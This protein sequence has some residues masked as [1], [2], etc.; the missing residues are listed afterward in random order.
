MLTGVDISAWQSDKNTP[1]KV[2]FVKMA[3]AGAKFAF[4]RAQFGLMKDVNFDEYVTNSKGLLKRGA[5]FFPIMAYNLDTQTKQFCDIVQKANLELPPVI[6]I[7]NYNGVPSAASIKV[8]IDTIQSRLHVK[9]IIYTGFYVWRDNVKGSNDAFFAN[10]PLWIATYAIN[11]MIPAP[12]KTW[13]FWQY[14]DKGDGIKY[15]VESLNI[16]MDSYNGTQA[17]FDAFTNSSTTT[18]IPIPN[19]NGDTAM[20]DTN[21][22]GIMLW[23]AHKGVTA[24]SLANYDFV[25]SVGWDGSTRN[26]E[27]TNHCQAAY[28]AKKPFIMLVK[29]YLKDYPGM[30]SGGVETPGDFTHFPSLDKDMNFLQM[31]KDVFMGAVGGSKRKINAVIVD[32]SDT[33]SDTGIIPSAWYVQICKYLVDGIFRR[34]SLPWFE[35]FS[36]TL[37]AEY[38]N[39]NDIAV[40]LTGDNV[41]TSVKYIVPTITS[42]SFPLPVA[43]PNAKI[44]YSSK[45]YYWWYSTFTASGITP[46]VATMIYNAKTKAELYAVIGF[47]D[48]AII[49]PTPTPT[50][51]PVIP[52]GETVT[53]NKGI[54]M[55][56]LGIINTMLAA[57]ASDIQDG[58]I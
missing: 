22:K 43:S 3:G 9:P 35:L 30:G 12:W 25:V 32:M 5:Y 47:T 56:R 23:S 49:A 51:E 7:E 50:P 42:G 20:Y 16:D 39:N 58:D 17:E 34:Y 11:P 24:A 18:T 21:P 45:W 44:P 29:P 19:P 33:A 53:L 1:A 31:D 37:L 52:G 57:L 46:A 28:E 2:D 55:A 27:F 38:P 40:Y 15:G 13:T 10:Y 54:I 41:G 6:D 48:S 14:T 8:M 4:F 36:S 26:P